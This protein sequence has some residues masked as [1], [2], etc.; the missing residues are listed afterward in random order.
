MQHTQSSAVA[1]GSTVIPFDDTP[2]QI[3]EGNEYLTCAI[4]PS[5]STSI[6]QVDVSLTLMTST[7]GTPALI[8]ALFRDASANA[9]AANTVISP[10]AN[11]PMIITIRHR[12]VA[13]S[14]SAITFRVRAGSNLAGTT[15]VN[16]N[17]G[18]RLFGSVIASS[19][20][21]TELKA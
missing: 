15:T 14:T 3:T 9:L 17:G 8:A 4:T 10:T 2:H 1:T 18:A 20:T 21:V 19:I 5:L 6:L 7:A 11:S 16:G 12:V 13:G